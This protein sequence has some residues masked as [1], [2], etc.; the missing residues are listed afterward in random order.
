M[1]INAICKTIN[2]QDLLQELEKGGE[3]IPKLASKAI[4]KMYKSADE[5]LIEQCAKLSNDYA[6]STSVT[7]LFVGNYIVI[8]HLGDSRASICY[9]NR[10][11]MVAKFLTVDHKPNNP[12]ERQRILASGGTVEFLC[13]HSNNPFIRGGDFAA[14]KARGDQPMQL[15]YSRAFGGKDLKMYGLS[16]VPEI[17][18]FERKAHHK[19][20]ILA[21][22]GLWDVKD[23]H[24]AFS[25]LF[26]AR[27]MGENPTQYLIESVIADQKSRARNSDNI[28][29]LAIF[30]D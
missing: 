12:E 23:S 26:Y 13:N 16:N 30:L 20:L 27:D 3:N 6:S 18:I 1:I 17:F 2:R 21:S 9:S 5:E 22:D 7:A 25:T 15:Q 28:T 11:K 4:F 10:G 19:C 24:E 29:V 8:S 14:R